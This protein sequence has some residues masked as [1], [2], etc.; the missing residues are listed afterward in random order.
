[1]FKSEII[2]DLKMSVKERGFFIYTNFGYLYFKIII[3]KFL[4][5]IN[6]KDRNT[7]ECVIFKDLLKIVAERK[8]TYHDSW[9]IYNSPLF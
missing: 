4:R 5:K 2:L 1:M 3:M 7:L 6:V 8:H 9:I